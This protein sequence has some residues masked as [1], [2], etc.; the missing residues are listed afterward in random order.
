MLQVIRIL[1]SLELMLLVDIDIHQQQ[2]FDL[3]NIIR[4]HA[5]VFPEWHASAMEELYIPKLF[6][7]KSRR[8]G[9]GSDFFCNFAKK[10]K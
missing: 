9:T 7:T 5:D 1:Q 4:E 2:F 10:K 6:K 8:E 3:V